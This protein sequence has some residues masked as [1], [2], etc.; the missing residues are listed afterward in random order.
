MQL[1]GGA[2]AVA[3]IDPS[4][5]L[6]LAAIADC[7]VISKVA[8]AG[9]EWFTG[10]VGEQ[11]VDAVEAAKARA[12]SMSYDEAVTYIFDNIER[13]IAEAEAADGATRRWP[14]TAERRE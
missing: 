9:F 2:E 3:D 10:L 13:L 6:D 14:V 1:P 12:R 5:A 11:G 7:G 8:V 4:F